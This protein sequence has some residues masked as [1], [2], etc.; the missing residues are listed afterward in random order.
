MVKD[1]SLDA[2]LKEYPVFEAGERG[3]LHCTL[4]NHDVPNT[5]DGLKSYV[6]TKKFQW[7]FELHK[8]MENYGEHFDDIG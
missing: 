6:E 8:F 3:K 1:R 5:Y 7:K 4:T 2:L